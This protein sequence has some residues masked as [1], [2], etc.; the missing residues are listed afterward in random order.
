MRYTLVKQ[1]SIKSV[2][3]IFNFFYKWVDFGKVLV[4]VFWAFLDIWYTFYL[5]FYNAFMYIYYLFLFILDRGS[6]ST[7]GYFRKFPVKASKAPSITISHEPNPIPAM[8][9][10]SEKTKEVTS[11]VVDSAASTVEKTTSAVSKS[12]DTAKNLTSFKTSKSSH[13]TPIIKTVL[14][15]LFEFFVS[16]KNFILLP[17]K[18]IAKAMSKKMKP[19]ESS[20]EPKHKSLVDEYMKQWSKKR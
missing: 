10:V 15:F 1:F 14:T 3:N 5:I 11:T 16:L 6:E 12:L 18:L 20:E 8:Y 19:M 17:Y 4:E 2:D 13:K 7:P 9:R